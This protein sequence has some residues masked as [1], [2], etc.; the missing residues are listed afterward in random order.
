RRS[1][2]LIVCLIPSLPQAQI[3]KKDSLEQI[4]RQRDLPSDEKVF[5]LGRLATH[6]YFNNGNATADSLLNEALQL[7]GTL[8]DKQYLAR[9]LALQA[10]Q[11]RL[12]G[13]SSTNATLQSALDNLNESADPSIKGYVWYAKGWIEARDEQ[14]AK[15]AESF[16]TALQYYGNSGIPTELTTKSGMMNALYSMCATWK[17]LDTMRKCAR[18][19]VDNAR[20]SAESQARTTGLYSLGYTCEEGYREYRRTMDARG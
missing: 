5:T 6:Y 2:D 1:S 14:P 8:E 9:T 15:A 4:L 16:I 17:D 13:D 7:A 10:M 3:A 11:L 18:M 20:K 12:Q 19:A